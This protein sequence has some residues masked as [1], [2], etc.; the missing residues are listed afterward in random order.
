MASNVKRFIGRH[1]AP[2]AYWRPPK[3]VEALGARP[4]PLDVEKAEEQALTLNDFWRSGQ[5]ASRRSELSDHAR[6]ML[7]A[8]KDRALKRGLTITIDSDWVAHRIVV[9]GF[10]CEVTKIAFD[11]SKTA[12]RVAPFR[13]SLDR[14]RSADGYTPDNVRLVCVAVNA[15]LGQWGDDVFF[16]VAEAALNARRKGLVR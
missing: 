7:K 14:I 1:G 5:E 12:T 16:R 8:A 3:D 2:Y 11:M 6:I 9:A 10:A 15:A 13:P 4:I